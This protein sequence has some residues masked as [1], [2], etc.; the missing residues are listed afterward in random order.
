MTPKN[1]NSADC[2]NPQEIPLARGGVGDLSTPETTEQHDENEY[3]FTYDLLWTWSSV[4]GY[5]KQD[6]R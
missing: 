5:S 4:D 6:Q 1:P 3:C 2:P